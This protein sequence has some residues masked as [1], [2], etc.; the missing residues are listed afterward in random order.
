ML[1]YRWPA[2]SQPFDRAPAGRHAAYADGRPHHI[3]VGRT[4]TGTDVL[5][6]VQAGRPPGPARTRQTPEPTIGEFG[7]PGCLETSQRCARQGSNLRPRAWKL[8]ESRRCARRQVRRSTTAHLHVVG[9]I[10]RPL[11]PGTA[12]CSRA[13]SDLATGSPSSDGRATGVLSPRGL[14]RPPVVPHCRRH[15][16]GRSPL[17]DT[18]LPTAV[19]SAPLP[20]GLSVPAALVAGRAL[21][22]ARDDYDWVAGAPA[23]S[24]R[25]GDARGGVSSDG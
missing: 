2:P 3:G 8:S 12:V 4:L 22:V 16:R 6:L 13:G 23:G 18:R 24:P 7:C 15:R 10:I 17:A 20:V 11:I 5:L 19:S 9:T 25:V 14:R 1:C 21:P